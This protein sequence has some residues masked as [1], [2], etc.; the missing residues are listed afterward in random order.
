[1]VAAAMVGGVLFLFGRAK[2]DRPEKDRAHGLTTALLVKGE[3]VPSAS[4]VGVEVASWQRRPLVLSPAGRLERLIGVAEG[5]VAVG[6]ME[7]DNGGGRPAV[8]ESRQDATWNLLTAFDRGTA[9][10][11]VARGDGILVFGFIEE[12]RGSVGCVWEYRGQAWRLLS[13]ETDPVLAGLVF[14]GAVVYN[15]L[16]VA[17]GRTTDTAGGWVSHDGANWERAGL[18]GSVD[19]IAAVPGT[20][21]GFGRDPVA[22]RPTVARSVDGLSWSELEEGATFVFEGAAI[23]AVV[24]FDGGIVAAGTDKMHGTAA[25]WV[26]DDGHRWLRT[27][28]QAEVGTSIQ[29]LAEMGD[30]LL[31]VGIDAGPK[32]TGRVGKVAVWESTDGVRWSR[33]Q[34]ADLFSSATVTSVDG[35]DGNILIAGKLQAGPGSP[36][37]EPVDV[38]WQRHGVP[39]GEVLD[40]TDQMVHS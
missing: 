4:E 31:A 17:Y 24:G 10:T 15:D 27:P 29:H 38:T 34:A 9:T 14:D 37:P 20:L 28:F 40:S 30:G 11:A 33:V 1:L 36:W 22:R 32:R 16:V 23:A 26:S 8:W 2:R 19:L 21:I 35:S 13:D 5:F 7:G 12:T 25:V 18:Q 3:R 39:D 6:Q